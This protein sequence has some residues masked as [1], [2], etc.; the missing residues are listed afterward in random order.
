MPLLPYSA[1]ALNLALRFDRSV[2]D[3]LF[4]AVAVAHKG[5]YVPADE[6]LVNALA[7]SDLARVVRLLGSEPTAS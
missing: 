3:A 6:R 4:L 2:D 7:Q 1:L 5:S